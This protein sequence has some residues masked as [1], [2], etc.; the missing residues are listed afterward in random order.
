M[1]GAEYCKAKIAATLPQF[2]KLDAMKRSDL[3]LWTLFLAEP[4]GLGKLAAL[5]RVIGSYHRIIV[6][7]APFGA[8]I[9][10]SHAIVSHQM[11]FQHFQLFAILQADNIVWLDR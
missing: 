7:Q 3:F 5:F 10:R 6:G 1:R 8:I 2:F 4:D 11:A 9:F